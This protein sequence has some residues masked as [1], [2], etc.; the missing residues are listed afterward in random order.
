VVPP[1]RLDRLSWVGTLPESVV[2][3]ERL[4]LHGLLLLATLFT[5]TVVGAGLAST[6]AAN[7]PVDL[8]QDFVI[9]FSLW[10]HPGLLLAGLPFSLTLLSI[11]MA[12]E[13][14]HYITCLRYGIDASLPYF[15]PAPTLIGTLGAFIRIRSPIYTRRALFDVGVAGPLAGFAL[16]VPALLL[17]LGLSR[18]HPGIAVQGDFVFG[19]P[20]LLR[21]LE[22]F[23]FPGVPVSD[24][25]LHPVARAAWVGILATALNLL[26]IGQLDGGHILYAFFGRQHKMLSRVFVAALVPIGIF[27]SWSWLVWAVLLAVFGLRHPVIFDA[28][29]LGS[30]RTRLGWFALAMFILCFTL[31]PIRNGG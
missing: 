13:M 6:F 7:R 3:R 16:L 23:V 19:T 4:W 22:T 26:P 15:L 27:F 10:H 29:A 25:S 12:H 2:R 8:E 18:V 1:A 14:G 9:I 28:S 20:L 17:G 21:I 11:L 24:I 30:T 31:A 5:T